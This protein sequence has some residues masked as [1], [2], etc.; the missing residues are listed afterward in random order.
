MIARAAWWASAVVT[1]MIGAI[2]V[3]ILAIDAVGP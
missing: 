1:A 3:Y 2:A